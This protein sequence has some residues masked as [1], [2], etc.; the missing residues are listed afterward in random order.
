MG[1]YCAV[2]SFDV[3]WW[4]APVGP[5]TSEEQQ[6]WD[7]TVV[8]T[9][10]EATKGRLGEIL[11]QARQR[12]LEAA[13]SER[14][15]PQLSY[16]ALAIEEVQEHITGLISL[17]AEIEHEEPH[18]IVRRLYRDAIEEELDFLLLIEATYQGNTERYPE[19][20][21]TFHS[22]PTSDEIQ[23]ALDPVR[24]YIQQS[25]LQPD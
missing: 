3:Y 9:R 1:G 5:L 2:A 23:Y 15:E 6:V 24:F 25:L 17:Q 11:Y 16:P 19:R 8:P 12:E 21:L 18:P 7:A 20:S 14:R 22:L 4:L 10:D 13:L